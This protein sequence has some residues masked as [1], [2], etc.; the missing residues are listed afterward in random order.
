MG[1]TSKIL[2]AIEASEASMKAVAYVAE[3]VR[4]HETIH[5][6]LF[7]A[8]PPIPPRLL[9]FGGT[10]DPQKEQELRTELKSAQSEW[11]EKAKDAVQPWITRARAILQDHGVS[12]S[13]ISTHFSHTIHKLDIVREI[14]NAA[15]QSDCGTVVVGRHR[16]PFVQDLFYHH[17][18]EGL[19]EQAQELAVWV[20]G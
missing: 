20:V 15:K 3:I 2:L 11:I 10:E 1:S 19:V 4:G 9:E 7:H 17:T 6:C 5:I 16:L 18:G 8:L 12:H 13:Q 14:L